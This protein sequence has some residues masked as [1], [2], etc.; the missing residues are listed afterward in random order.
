MPFFEGNRPMKVDQ[1]HVFRGWVDKET[2]AIAKWGRESLGR[3]SDEDFM[4]AYNTR[5]NKSNCN[6]QEIINK[7]EQMLARYNKYQDARKLEQRADTRDKIKTLFFRILTTASIAAIILGTGWI[8]DTY[9]IPLPLLR[10][11]G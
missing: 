11:A 8:A 7:Y 4:T 9:N 3:F 6:F 2:L 5:W 1:P 10:L